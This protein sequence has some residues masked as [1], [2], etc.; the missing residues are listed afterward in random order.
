MRPPFNRYMPGNAVTE[1]AELLDIRYM[2][3][4]DQRLTGLQGITNNRDG[5]IERKMY[6][7]SDRKPRRSVELMKTISKTCA[8]RGLTNSRSLATYL[9]GYT[10]LCWRLTAAS[11]QARNSS[12]S[13]MTLKYS[14]SGSESR[15]S[16]RFGIRAANGNDVY[17]IH[18]L[19]YTYSVVDLKAIFY[20]RPDHLSAGVTII[21]E[22]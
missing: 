9:A 14:P 15:Y 4:Q 8:I 18:F 6:S 5:S 12:S 7:Y 13:N 19:T 20:Q 21:N 22:G 16:P 11:P 2:V 17:C 1:S 3:V 10:F